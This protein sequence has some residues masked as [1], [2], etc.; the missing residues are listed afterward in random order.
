MHEE[1]IVP[2]YEL[3][4]TADDAK[5]DW[6][7]FQALDG[8]RKAEMVAFRRVKALIEQHYH[9]DASLGL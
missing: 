2:K 5:M 4:E 9:A 8:R 6:E 1:D 7:A 3:M